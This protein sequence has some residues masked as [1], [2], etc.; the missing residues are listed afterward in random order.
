MKNHLQCGASF[1]GQNR[2]PPSSR[3]AV[4]GRL[5][6]LIAAAAVP[7]ASVVSGRATTILQD[8]FET[9]DISMPAYKYYGHGDTFSIWTVIDDGIGERPYLHANPPYFVVEG[10]QAMELNQGSGVRTTFNA[11]AGETYT[12]SFLLR[13]SSNVQPSPLEVSAAGQ[14]TTFFYNVDKT[15]E[16]KTFTFTPTLNDPAAELRLYNPSP[17]GDYATWSIDAVRLSVPD[18]AS[19]KWLLIGAVGGLFLVV[20]KMNDRSWLRLSI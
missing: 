7:L 15:Y 20:R 1:H 5:L 17:V 8:G 14:S 12:L 19:T 9:P 2:L 6:P 11:V 18:A 4:P 13:H 16:L 10:T 3:T